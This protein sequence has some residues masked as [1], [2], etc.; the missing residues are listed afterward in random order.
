[1][2]NP[3]R[4]KMFLISRRALDDTS[5]EIGWTTFE[6]YYKPDTFNPEIE[7]MG[8]PLD[9]EAYLKQK[10]EDWLGWVRDYNNGD[11]VGIE[12]TTRQSILSEWKWPIIS[13][14]II[15]ALLI[16]LEYISNQ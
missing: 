1:M 7:I 11:V 10:R 2:E 16:A 12:E 3:M 6:L 15:V 9:E 14:P 5:I 4:A 13:V 8:D